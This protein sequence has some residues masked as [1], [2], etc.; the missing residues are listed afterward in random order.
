[1]VWSNRSSWGVKETEKIFQFF[2]V[3][4]WLVKKKCDMFCSKLVLLAD[5]VIDGPLSNLLPYEEEVQPVHIVDACIKLGW[6]S[7]ELTK[8]TEI[9]PNK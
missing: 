9:S 7:K 6:A 8:G 4:R 2:S 5:Q 1:M 3:G